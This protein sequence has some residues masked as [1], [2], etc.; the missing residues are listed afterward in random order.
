MKPMIVASA[1][2]V[3]ACSACKKEQHQ[4]WTSGDTTVYTEPVPGQPPTENMVRVPASS[5]GLIKEFF[6]DKDEVTAG[7][8]THC[9]SMKRC[10]PRD[11]LDVCR[12]EATVKAKRPVNCIDPKMADQY[13]TY[14][15]KRLPTREEWLRAVHGDDSRAFPWGAAPPTC[16]TAVIH[17][18][19]CPAEHPEDVG[20]RRDG[21][22]PYGVMDMVGNVSEIVYVPPPLHGPGDYVL[23]GGNFS[24]APGTL[25][26]E[27]LQQEPPLGW[28][29]PQFGFRCAWSPDP[30][31]P[32]PSR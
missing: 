26:H 32:S 2:L 15:G 10:D 9:V 21:A 3:S 28:E 6:I 19:Q 14:R 5:D 18:T 27:G 1:L 22:T 31:K 16:K 13:C 8:Y 24:S 30:L 17:D 20:S 12:D 25:V 11:Y 7:E 23:M 29:A 4:V